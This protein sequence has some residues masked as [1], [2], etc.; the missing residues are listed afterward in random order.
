MRHILLTFSLASRYVG[1]ALVLW[2][3]LAAA[4]ESPVTC[5]FPVGAEKTDVATKKLA[6]DIFVCD[7]SN[8]EYAVV[9]NAENA[10]S[11]STAADGKQEAFAS[12]DANLVT[13]D[14]NGVADIFLKNLA[15]QQV[16]QRVSV[17]TDG[18]QANG[19]S[20]APAMS[21]KGGFVA[22]KSAATNLAASDDLGADVFVHDLASGA[23]VHLGRLLGEAPYGFFG[24]LPAPAGNGR[25]VAVRRDWLGSLTSWW[26]DHPAPATDFDIGVT[27][28][29]YTA[30]S[31]PR[32]RQYLDWYFK[33]S[34]PGPKA[35]NV[36][37]VV[38]PGAA[39][40][41]AMPPQ[42]LQEGTAIRC[43]IDN[44]A[45]NSFAEG[46]ITVLPT[47]TGP[48]TSHATVSADET[49]SESNKENNSIPPLDF[50]VG[51]AFVQLVPTLTEP[52]STVHAGERVDY[53]FAIENKGTSI[54]RNV[55]AKITVGSPGE[56]GIPQGCE[57]NGDGSNGF[58]CSVDTLYNSIG[59]TFQ[60]TPAS[61]SD[62]FSVT[63]T[64]E[65]VDTATATVLKTVAV[66]EASSD[67]QVVELIPPATAQAGVPLDFDFTVINAGPSNASNVV[68]TATLGAA[69]T[70]SVPSNCDAVGTTGFR[71]AIGSL[72]SGASI[73]N[74]ITATPATNVDF[75]VTLSLQGLDA[76]PKADNNSKTATKT[77][78]AAPAANLKAVLTPPSGTVRANEWVLY[79]F[80]TSN[81]GPS[82]ATGVVFT[83]TL[84]SG[85]VISTPHGCQTV[86]AK[87]FTC[88]GL[89]SGDFYVNPAAA[90]DLRV[91]I[92]VA[93]A[94]P[95]PDPSDN[96]DVHVLKVAPAATDLKASLTAVSNSLRV[97]DV[98]EYSFSVENLGQQAAT[99]V[100]VT[101]DFGA[102]VEVAG[103]NDC[104]V[105]GGQTR[106]T[107]NQLDDGRALSAKLRAGASVAGM[108]N[109]KLT[110]TA[111]TFD[112]NPAN[113]VVNLATPVAALPD[114]DLSLTIK[115]AKKSIKL[116]KR[117][118]ITANVRN[119]NRNSAAEGVAFRTILPE[120]LDY[121]GGVGCA[122][123]QSKRL[124]ACNLGTVAA[125]KKKPVKLQLLGVAKG[126]YKQ[127]FEVSGLIT[128][129]SRGNNAVSLVLLVK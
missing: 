24:I 34:N 25:Y 91:K 6:D 113:N 27:L 127:T 86:N 58:T 110:V 44:I 65:S 88:A 36:N 59:V 20:N 85:G 17:A 117:F 119:Q 3:P 50:N 106:C 35:T 98:Q 39:E 29:G 123:D 38:T 74:K 120:G 51:S 11:S 1:L 108:L 7:L 23:T 40:I 92:S 48:Q 42:C 97:G 112:P 14:T 77:G 19:A 56:V 78:I 125:K 103:P 8:G 116:G 57:K 60:V 47:A 37:V 75:P 10:S 45:S 30:D 21:T 100:V 15:T 84:E 107:V 31:T 43:V 67:L 101:V 63:L 95:D 121:G 124:V 26:K 71:C 41:V 105:K 53:S 126:G 94:A 111:A 55:K 73:V 72:A 81:A 49:V 87:S 70:I 46:I 122:Y 96:T 66:A 5:V 62:A 83:A 80:T 54:I 12:S 69:G 79:S 18:S 129:R 64:V 32:V 16:T 13:G 2:A 114:G 76:D 128:D 9:S 61:A 109:A 4:A 68:L 115:V 90:G 93:G 52:S 89:V 118:M 104:T 28:Q 22:F 99:G 82:D 102:G 33:V